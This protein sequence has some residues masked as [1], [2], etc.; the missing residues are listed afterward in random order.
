[1]SGKKNLLL[2]SIHISHTCVSSAPLEP[3][4]SIPCPILKMLKEGWERSANEVHVC[5]A[6]CTKMA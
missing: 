6:V 4:G 3:E 2:E 1:M 5:T